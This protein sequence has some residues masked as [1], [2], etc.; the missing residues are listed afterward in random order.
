MSAFERITDSSPTSRHVCFVPTSDIVRYTRPR[1]RRPLSESPIRS[2]I[3]ATANVANETGPRGRKQ[4]ILIEGDF[5][6]GRLW[7]KWPSPG[8]TLLPPA[9]NR[10]AE[11]RCQ[12]LLCSAAVRSSLFATV[13]RC[14]RDPLDLRAP[15]PQDDLDSAN[16][17]DSR[18]AGAS[19]RRIHHIMLLD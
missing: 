8:S 3:S 14:E 7:P 10:V 15:G 13:A 6:L 9:G 19:R 12:Q 16:F 11:V 1:N 2:D 17:G 4:N 5:D 18:Q